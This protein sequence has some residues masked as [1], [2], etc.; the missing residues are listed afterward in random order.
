MSASSTWSHSTRFFP[1]FPANG[2]PQA[3]PTLGSPAMLHRADTSVFKKSLEEKMKV[4]TFKKQLGK[5]KNH[6][7]YRVAIGDM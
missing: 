7:F 2:I 5:T 6:K 3:A 4:F 1:F